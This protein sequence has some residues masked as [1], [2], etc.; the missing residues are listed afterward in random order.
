MA[1]DASRIVLAK[2]NKRFVLYLHPPQYALCNHKER[3]DLANNDQVSTMSLS[4]LFSLTRNRLHYSICALLP[5]M[6]AHQF[7]QKDFLRHR[8]LH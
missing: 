3:D 7:P 8:L 5:A 6:Q 2:F 1:S 4:S